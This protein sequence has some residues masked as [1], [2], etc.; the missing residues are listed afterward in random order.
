MKYRIKQLRIV[1]NDVLYVSKQTGTTNKKVTILLAIF[2]SNLTAILDI[3][4][5]LILTL[6]F[7]GEFET[8]RTIELA[9]NFLDNNMFLLPLV[10]IVRFSSKLFQNY[11]IKT[12]EV[13]VM[14]NLKVNVMTQ[15]FKEKD[16]Q[17]Q[18]HFFT[19]IKLQHMYHFFILR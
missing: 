14:K 8:F 13:T 6:F 10:I 18:M 1:L 15:I 17:L 3:A 2:A 9:I 5:I 4:I 11:L 7:T 19:L 16:F 12:L